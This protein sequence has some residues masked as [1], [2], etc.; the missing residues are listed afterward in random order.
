MLTTNEL[1]HKKGE[2]I[3][4]MFSS[5]AARY[6]F[7][8]GLLSLTFDRRWRR[9]AVSV[10]GLQEGDKVLDVCTGTGDLAI[11]YAKAVKSLES[12]VGS[13]ESK[14][15]T[16]DSELR[17]Q[18]SYVVGTDFCEEMLRLAIPKLRVGSRELGVGS[19]DSRLKF[20]EADTL[21]L[22]FADGSFQV[23]A[24]AFGIRNVADLGMGIR[25]MARVISPGGRVVILEF[26]KPENKVFKWFYDLYFH[27]ILPVIGRFF[28][29][30]DIDAYTYLPGSVQAFPNG[31]ELK[32]LM[33]TCVLEDVKI[34]PRTFGI[35]N[36][37]VGK[38]SDPNN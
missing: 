30:S 23:S 35:V 1:L 4:R 10:S 37:L 22:P 17:T 7:L 29:A 13:Q 36:I 26:A 14:T 12:G 33:E 5:I 32:A 18:D 2:N 34:Y 15:K 20:I 21:Y 27:K 11:E 19:Q 3:R 38:K 31:Q 8:N 28:S 9:F 16:Q 24:V 25:E 6:D